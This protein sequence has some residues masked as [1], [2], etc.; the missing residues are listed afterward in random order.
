[1]IE[2]KGDIKIKKKIIIHA[3]FVINVIGL[4]I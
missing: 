3:L 1:M 4:K 2:I